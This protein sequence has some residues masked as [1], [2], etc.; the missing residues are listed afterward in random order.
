MNERPTALV[1]G[2]SGGIGEALATELASRG[3]NV[4]VVA[5]SGPALE[6]LA[7]QLRRD[8]RV[9]VTVIIQDLATPGA[10][11]ALAADLASRRI[12]LDILVNNAGFADFG[13]FMEADPNTLIMMANLNMVTLT[14]LTRL[15]GAPM[16]ERG[17]GRIL[18]IA[19]TAAFMPGPL[20]AEYYATKAYVLSL[21]EALADELDGTGVTITTLCPGPTASG[22][23]DRAAMGASKLVK[24]KSLDTAA[25]VARVGVEAMLTGKTLAIVGLK[26]KVQALAPKF[27]PRRMVP[28]MVH[29]AQAA[30]HPKDDPQHNGQK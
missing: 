18:N 15:I 5:R 21:G 6:A 24:G 4:V 1:T 25:S 3:N 11:V 19:S 8:H 20:M 9:E 16:V 22:F 10:G 27:M 26:N 29:R 28:A 13:L 12:E 23:Q 2:A 7:E 30:S 14:E 17:A